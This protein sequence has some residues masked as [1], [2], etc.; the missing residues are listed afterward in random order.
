MSLVIYFLE[1]GFLSSKTHGYN[2][3]IV[4]IVYISHYSDYVMSQDNIVSQRK[5]LTF[6]F[7]LPYS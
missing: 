5:H 6:L 7:V 1:M 3:D 4:D 2:P